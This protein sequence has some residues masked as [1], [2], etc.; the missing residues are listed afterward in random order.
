MPFERTD[1][2]ADDADDDGE[3]C[4]FCSPIT[5][6][7]QAPCRH[8]GGAVG[9]LGDS[10]DLR[11]TPSSSIQSAFRSALQSRFSPARP[12]EK[13]DAKREERHSL[14]PSYEATAAVDTAQDA[15]SEAWRW[16]STRQQQQQQQQK[17]PNTMSSPRHTSPNRASG[18]FFLKPTRYRVNN[19][20]FFH[21]TRFFFIR[22]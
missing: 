14:F 3:R 2:A 1:D 4:S 18:R 16:N 7:M 20:T 8:G 15:K 22:T 12:S 6:L 19:K 13:I 10:L 17:P 11:S 9:G 5:T 21:G